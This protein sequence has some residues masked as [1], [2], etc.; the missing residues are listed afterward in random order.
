[1]TVTAGSMSADAWAV[2]LVIKREERV[3]TIEQLA[4]HSGIGERGQ[5]VKPRQRGRVANALAELED[6]TLLERIGGGY[7]IRHDRAAAL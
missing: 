1:M 7:V 5:G 6:L 2:W 4:Q 3:G